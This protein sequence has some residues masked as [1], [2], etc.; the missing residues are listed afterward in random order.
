VRAAEGLRLHTGSSSGDVPPS[1]PGKDESLACVLRLRLAR[2]L[3]EVVEA[4]ETFTESRLATS[5]MVNG[6]LEASLSD[7]KPL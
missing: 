2:G 6:S 3:G 1:S 7:I 5:Q 4:V